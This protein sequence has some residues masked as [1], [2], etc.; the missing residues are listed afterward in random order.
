MAA[1]NVEKVHNIIYWFFCLLTGLIGYEIHGSG[2]WAFMDFLLA[3]IAWVKWI[4]LH[5]VNISIIKAAFSW[6]LK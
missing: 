5:E 2:F 6:F 3:P 1:T 4:I